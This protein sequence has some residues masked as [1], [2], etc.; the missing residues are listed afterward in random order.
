VSVKKRY[1]WTFLCHEVAIAF[2]TGYSFIALNW[3]LLNSSDGVLRLGT[4][5]S[6]GAAVGVIVIPLMG[7]WSD[8]AKDGIIF[9][10]FQTI[11]GILLI[12]MGFIVPYI[13]VFS[14]VLIASVIIN[15]GWYGYLA[16]SR[17]FFK[18]FSEEGKHGKNNMLIEVF[19]QFGLFM[20]GPILSISYTAIG[21]RGILYISG[22][23]F[24]LSGCVILVLSRLTEYAHKDS[25]PHIS[26]NAF[27]TKALGNKVLITLAV[28][29][30]ALIMVSNLIFPYIIGKTLNLGVNVYGI[31]D[32]L[33]G[34]GAFCS[35]FFVIYFMGNH[36]DHHKVTILFLLGGGAFLGLFIGIFF[37]IESI[38]LVI[39]FVKFIFGLVIA[40]LRGIFN[41]IY[42][43]AFEH[44]MLARALAFTTMMSLT[45]H[46][47]LS[48]S[49]TYV[50]KTTQSADYALAIFIAIF[51]VAGIASR[52]LAKNN[53]KT[54]Q[55]PS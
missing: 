14:F 15:C 13:S 32:M 25:K 23:L 37:N 35:G 41:A 33:S 43:E 28:L 53:S 27:Y 7:I 49:L 17:D 12:A 40:S 1:F 19:L 36:K 24:I 30:S 47:L 21:I 38:V 9:G 22:S 42:F 29:P 5:L 2:A 46:A 10:L 16:L 18:K 34:I 55:R 26:F 8:R 39:Y 51:V 11:R 20:S 52:R 4:F 45:L 31:S 50:L 3:H 6:V 48:L 44:G 54:I